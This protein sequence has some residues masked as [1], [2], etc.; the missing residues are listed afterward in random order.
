MF[1]HRE[2]VEDIFLTKGRPV[3]G[4]EHVLPQ[5][6]LQAEEKSFE[7]N[8]CIQENLNVSHSDVT[9]ARLISD[10]DACFGSDLSQQGGPLK[11]MLLYDLLYTFTESRG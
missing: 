5:L 4:V 11:A 1:D 9:T 6:Y 7:H 2:H 8:S 3:P 10:L